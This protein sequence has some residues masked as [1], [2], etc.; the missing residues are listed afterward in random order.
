M[1]QRPK[2]PHNRTLEISAERQKFTWGLKDRG[3][4]KVLTCYMRNSCRKHGARSALPYA[5][6]LERGVAGQQISFHTKNILIMSY[7]QQG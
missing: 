3:W 4:D 7:T 5:A 2:F 6:L 1:T